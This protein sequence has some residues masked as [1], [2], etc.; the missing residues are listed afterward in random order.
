M[1]VAGRSAPPVPVWG[2]CRYGDRSRLARLTPRWVVAL[3]KVAD[4][5]C[6]TADQCRASDDLLPHLNERHDC[7]GHK[8][9]GADPVGADPVCRGRRQ[10]EHEFT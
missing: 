1:S 3:D 5:R 7:R 8:R 10:V 9:D 4:H 6:T 2:R